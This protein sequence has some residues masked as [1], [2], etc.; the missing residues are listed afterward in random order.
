ML[1]CSS[2]A[3]REG[4]RL[5]ACQLMCHT[6]SSVMRW[7]SITSRQQCDSVL[8]RCSA[9]IAVSVPNSKQH[10]AA[11]QYGRHVGLL[12]AAVQCGSAVRQQLMCH[13]VSSAE[14]RCCRKR[15]CSAAV[16]CGTALRW[17]AQQRIA[18]CCAAEQCDS[19]VRQQSAAPESS[20]STCCFGLNTN[21]C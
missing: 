7:S 12:C 14:Q 1:Q 4:G 19:I 21:G 13:S 3:V 8:R 9:A 15:Q 11:E 10:S 18:A 2:A 17:G 6:V 16:Q 5:S 20:C